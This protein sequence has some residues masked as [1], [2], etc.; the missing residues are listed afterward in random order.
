[1]CVKSCV[2]SSCTGVYSPYEYYSVRRTIEQ[3]LLN[4]FLN[5]QFRIQL[6]K[7]IYI[8][9]RLMCTTKLNTVHNGSCLWITNSLI[10][11]MES[12]RKHFYPNILAAALI[13]LLMYRIWYTCS[14]CFQTMFQ[15]ASENFPDFTR[16]WNIEKSFK[17]NLQQI[18]LIKWVKLKK[19][20]IRYLPKF[21]NLCLIGVKLTRKHLLTIKLLM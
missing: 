12:L 17:I 1:M 7:I 8:D 11:H 9:T 4:F 15:Y 5:P 20:I 21:I 2:W 3:I 18:I 16:N 14:M 13:F 10:D 19:N 6:L